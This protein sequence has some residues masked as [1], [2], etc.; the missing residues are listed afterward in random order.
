MRCVLKRDSNDD[1]LCF[2]VIFV[3]KT[4]PFRSKSNFERSLKTNFSTHPHNY[5]GLRVLN[6]DVF[7]VL[8]NSF[9]YHKHRTIAYFLGNFYSNLNWELKAV[10]RCCFVISAI[11]VSRGI[12]ILVSRVGK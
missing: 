11:L 4:W 6:S 7:E 1:F 5:S 10:V 12:T 9:V 8:T 2:V 3:G